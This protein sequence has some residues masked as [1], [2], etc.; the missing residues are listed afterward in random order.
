MY[1]DDI[2]LFAENEKDFEILI[3]AVK[4]YIQD[5]GMKFGMCHANN[6]K[7]EATHA[8]RNRTVKLRNQNSWGKGNLLL[9]GNIR[10][11]Y[12]QTSGDERKKSKK[13]ISEERENYLKTNYISGTSSRE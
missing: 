10:N 4:I 3:Q 2:K 11:G 13:T 9:L 8:G 1:I 12:N 7:R 6:Q 5:I